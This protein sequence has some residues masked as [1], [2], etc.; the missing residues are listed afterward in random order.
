MSKEYYVGD[1]FS[2][3]LLETFHDLT[4]G[5]RRVKP[6]GTFPADIRVEFPILLRKGVPLGTQY[7]A[8]V[9]VCQ[10][11][12]KATGK[13]FGPIYLSAD[14]KTITLE[15][16]YSPIQQ[17]SANPKANH[18]E[19]YVEQPESIKENP[20]EHLR[21][22]AYDVAVDEIETSK[23]TA[24]TR[25]RNKKI[26]AYAIERS[27]GICEACD[28]PAPFTTRNGNPYLEVHHMKPVSEG[29]PDHPINVA[30]IC[31]NCHRRTEKSQDSVSFNA[32]LMDRIVEKEESM[33]DF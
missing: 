10:K 4:K 25:A 28:D 32:E 11:T 12:K 22:A 15:N 3:V 6:I 23:T 2:G 18:L 5:R 26:R 19:D 8:D 7:R 24:K 9:K 1:Y 16:I 27:K 17:I 13:P 14:T 29:G 33:G 21:A 20:L 30:A 31:P